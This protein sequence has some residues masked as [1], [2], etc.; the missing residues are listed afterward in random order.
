MAYLLT[1]LQHSESSSKCDNLILNWFYPRVGKEYYCYCLCKIYVYLG[2]LFLWKLFALIAI[3]Q[4]DGRQLNASLHTLYVTLFR[5]LSEEQ[6]S[7]SLLRKGVLGRGKQCPG[8]RMQGP[9]YGKEKSSHLFL[10]PHLIEGTQVPSKLYKWLPDSRAG[11]LF[12][13]DSLLSLP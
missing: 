6:R 1:A 4:K 5:G 11:L 3:M 8:S 2:R 9:N 10:H 13:R 12:F 7:K